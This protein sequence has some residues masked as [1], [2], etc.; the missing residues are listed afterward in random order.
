MKLKYNFVVNKVVDKYVAVA[1]GDDLEKFN[2]FVKMNSIG[3][4][5]FDMLKEDITVEQVVDAMAEKHPDAEIEDVKSTVTGFI[6][7]LKDSEII[8]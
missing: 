7:K 8:E 2:G 4:E 3:A 6:E 5:I 1:V